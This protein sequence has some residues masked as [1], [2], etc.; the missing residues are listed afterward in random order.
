VAAPHERLTYHA[1]AVSAAQN[2]VPGLLR[3]VPFRRVANQSKDQLNLVRKLPNLTAFLAQHRLDATFHASDRVLDAVPPVT[4]A[5]AAAATIEGAGAA[6]V[7]CRRGDKVASNAREKYCPRHMDAATSP[8]RIAALLREFDVAPGA[9][10]Y[11]MSNDLNLTHFAPL[12]DVHGY[13]FLT[14]HDF[15]HLTNLTRG[16]AGAEGQCENYL[17]YAM[18][19]EIMRSVP[20]KRRFVTLPKQ[21]MDHNPTTLYAPYLHECMP[22]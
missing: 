18:E 15:P 2:R 5:L 21:D 12:R 13:P 10:V 16:C 8:A 6:V 20:R 4:A 9:A 14:M 3:R 1:G 22:H 11:L 19:T 7:H 17:L